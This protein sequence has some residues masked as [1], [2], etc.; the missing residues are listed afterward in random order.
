[1]L[2][3]SNDELTALKIPDSELW[4]VVRFEVSNEGWISW[5]HEREWRCK[6]DFTLPSS[7]Q[8]AF[9]RTTAEAEKLTKALASKPDKFKCKPR[10][11]IPMT[12]LCQGLLV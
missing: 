7:I 10:S 5:L 6:G 2:Y 9:V 4:R 12:V 11:V 3:L 1:V 8:A